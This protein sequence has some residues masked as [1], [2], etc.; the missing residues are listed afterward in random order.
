MPSNSMRVI[1]T[2][3]LGLLNT[4]A[5]QVVIFSPGKTG[6]SLLDAEGERFTR[7]TINSVTVSFK[8]TASTM[9]DGELAWA[10]V[11]GP[12]RAEIKD[13]TTVLKCKPFR[14]H[15]IW[16]SESLSVGRNIAPQ[17]FLYCNGTG[18]D[19]VAFTLYIQPSKASLPGA[20]AITYDLSLS[21]PNP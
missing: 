14:L 17:P 13:K 6:L 15:A 20:F 8:A 1:N 7:Y 18:R 19:E 10:L 11:A 12:M 21:F 2:E 5:L 4:G 16:K 3:V 9:V